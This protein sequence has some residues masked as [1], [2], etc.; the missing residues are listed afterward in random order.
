MW[1]AT[2]AAPSLHIEHQRH[3]TSAHDIVFAGRAEQSD[4][5]GKSIS[6]V[7]RGKGATFSGLCTG[8]GLVDSGRFWRLHV[9]SKHACR[10]LFTVIAHRA[11][12]SKQGLSLEGSNSGQACFEQSQ[13]KKSL[14]IFGL[15]STVAD[16]VLKSHHAQAPTSNYL[17]CLLAHQSSSFLPRAP[18]LMS[19]SLQ[20]QRLQVRAVLTRG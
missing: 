13:H 11:L 20:W 17:R 5:T 12:R 6:E 3:Q 4:L 10:H 8:K 15:R 18:A 7:Y 14:L 19:Q 2:A 16:N 9:N 1:I